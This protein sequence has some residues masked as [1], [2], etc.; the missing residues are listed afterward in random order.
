MSRQYSVNFV[1]STRHL[2]R[3]DCKGFETMGLI[4]LP[5]NFCNDRWC[6]EEEK[7]I[8]WHARKTRR[9]IHWRFLGAYKYWRIYSVPR[10]GGAGP[11]HWPLHTWEGFAT[12]SVAVYCNLYLSLIQTTWIIA[13]LFLFSS[14]KPHTPNK[15]IVS[16]IYTK[17]YKALQASVAQYVKLLSF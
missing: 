7:G 9:I 1:N 6:M 16:S 17:K 11:A 8:S 5:C 10:S 15:R 14:R 3:S 12:R 4:I 13:I 2:T